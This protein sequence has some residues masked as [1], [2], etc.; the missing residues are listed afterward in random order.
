MPFSSLRRQLRLPPAW[1]A[2]LAVAADAAV[3][4]WRTVSGG[5]AAQPAY[6]VHSLVWPGI[7]VLA[8]VYL[9]AWLG[10]ALDID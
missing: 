10:W 4:A 6:F 5:G 2:L 8:A 7:G 3:A 1:S 9:F